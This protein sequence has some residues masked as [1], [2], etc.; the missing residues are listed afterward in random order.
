MKKFLIP[1]CLCFSLLFSLSFAVTID[2]SDYDLPD[3]DT[4]GNSNVYSNYIIYETSNDA[5]ICLFTS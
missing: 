5:T 4:G 2:L 1:L 3:L